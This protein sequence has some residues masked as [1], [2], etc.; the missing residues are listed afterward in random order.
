MNKLAYTNFHPLLEPHLGML[1][2]TMYFAPLT[3]MPNLID[4]P[5]ID[6]FCN[7]LVAASNR[8]KLLGKFSTQ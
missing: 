5:N 2:Y 8:G 4:T 1:K 3:K 7:Y 6:H